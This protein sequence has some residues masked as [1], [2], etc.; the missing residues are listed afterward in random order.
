MVVDDDGNEL[1]PGQTGLLI[2]KKPWPGLMLDIY[3]DPDRYRESYWSRF[4]GSYYA[5]DFA[6]QDKDGYFWMIG[7]ADEV[8]NIA[9]HRIGTAEMEDA[10]ISDP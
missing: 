2:I 7:R 4:P 10:V 8:L 6:M 5:G 3:G 9:G 1:P